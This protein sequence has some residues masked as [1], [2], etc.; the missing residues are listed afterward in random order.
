V[1][2]DLYRKRPGRIRLSAGVVL[3][4]GRFG[5]SRKKE[6]AARHGVCYKL[7]AL[8]AAK[9]RTAHWEEDILA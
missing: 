5:P 1:T 2:T 7:W 8:N 3:W 4:P 6:A 9:V